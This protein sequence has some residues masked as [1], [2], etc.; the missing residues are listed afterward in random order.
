MRELQTNDFET[1]NIEYIEFWLMDPFV[2]DSLH[3]GGDLYFN[4]GEISEDVLKDSRKFF[5]N[6]LPTT[7]SLTRVDSNTVWG[8]VPTV[9]SIVNTFDADPN[10]RERQD[11]GLDGL[12]DENERLKFADWLSGLDQGSPYFER[13]FQDPANDN[14]RYFLSPDYI[15]TAGVISRYKDYNNMQGNSPTTEQS[16]GDFAAATT[17]PNTEDIT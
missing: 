1:S 5:E 7:D 3:L 8:R 15:D 12:S 11:V 17:L 10:N 16:G 9:Q 4:L 13:A 6:G 14:F 2:N